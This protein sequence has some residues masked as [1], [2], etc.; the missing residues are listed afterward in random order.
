M[1][2]N[3]LASYAQDA[4]NAGAASN[5]TA[6]A[7]VLA[8]QRD[9]ILNKGVAVS[10]SFDYSYTCV[11]S[12]APREQRLIRHSGDVNTLGYDSWYLLPFGRGYVSVSD[13]NAYGGNIAI[14]P[15]FFVNAFDRLAQ[16]ATIRFTRTVSQ[17]APL[18]ND[19]VAEMTPGTGAV[20]QGASLEQW[21][22]WAEKNY[23]S[24]W[25]REV[26]CRLRGW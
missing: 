2:Q 17:A 5:A 4:V 20:P 26:R 25:V 10:E 11:A 3:N 1:L 23:R 6:L 21:A 16:A 24:N 7:A 14:N 15:R 13:A 18:A 19:V 22:Q 9:W 8:I 12:L